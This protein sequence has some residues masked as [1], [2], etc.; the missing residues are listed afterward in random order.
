MFFSPAVGVEI[1]NRDSTW[2]PE[3]WH[4]MAEVSSND[5]SS[6]E[7]EVDVHVLKAYNE[8]MTRIASLT[9]QKVKHVSVRLSKE[10]E[11]AT[12]NEKALCL[13][14]VE[15]ACR[16]VC[17]VIAPRDSEELLQAFKTPAVNEVCSDDLIT[18]ITAYKQAP[19]KNL[20]TQI[21][22]IYAPRY[23]ARFLKKIHEP[24]EKL[25]DRQIKKARAHAK[26]VGAG[27]N[28]NKMPHH[29]VRIDLVKLDHFLS[30]VDQPY[31]Y[32][33]V[34]YGTRTLKLDS[35]DHLVMPNVIRIVGRST[36]IEQYLKHCCEEDFD[37]LGKSTLYRIL[38]VRE[39]SQRWSLQGLD[40]TAVSGAEG[41][42][43]MHKIVKEL[44]EGGATEKWC[45]EV[46]RTLKDAKRYMKTEYGMHC[47]EDGSPCPDHS[48]CFSLNDPQNPE[49]QGS[50]SHEHQVSCDSLKSVIQALGKE[51]ETP[52][53]TF[54]N[55]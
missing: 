38:Q 31:F 19:S 48:M 3:Q 26:N 45:E 4:E 24:F 43:A 16:A 1:H 12:A 50:C 11:E 18:L 9:E 13:D 46:R 44:E 49:F 14:H 17:N 32:Q 42:E 22:S 28:L 21:L 15:E 20:K 6:D 53:I 7:K 37:P 52:S 30:F 33:G 23:S 41:F 8:A 39:A 55:I 34:A 25:S 10:W 54:D 47:Q 36:M 35:G 27:F 51:I 40:N 5:D 2:T 29:R